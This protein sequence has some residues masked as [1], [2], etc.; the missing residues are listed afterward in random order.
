MKLYV[1]LLLFISSSFFF[2]GC[3]KNKPAIDQL[4]PATQTGARTFGCLVDGKV[5]KPKGD[6]FSGPRLSCAYQYNN[7]GYSFQLKAKQDIGNG[8]LSIGIF[9]DSLPIS[10]GVII[11][12]YEPFVKGKS[13]GLHGKYITGSS[14]SLYYSQ[15][16]G[17]GELH[18]T[19]FDERNQIVSGTFWFDGVNDN[20]EKVLVREG[21]FDMP[22]TL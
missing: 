16:S 5:F 14:G 10:Q 6:L 9:T 7:G 11:K 20:G 19:K 4:P 8:L 3:R 17:T 18:I 21:R 15:P 12:L 22:Y 13:F 2:A 1:Y